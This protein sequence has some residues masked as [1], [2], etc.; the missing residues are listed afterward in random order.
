MEIYMLDMYYT[1]PF[2]YITIYNKKSLRYFIHW[3]DTVITRID[4]NLTNI[5]NLH[6]LEYWIW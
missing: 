4:Y 3:C 2:S 1:I 6:M 5:H